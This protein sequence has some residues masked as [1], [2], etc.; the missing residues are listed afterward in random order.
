MPRQPG[1]LVCTSVWAWLQSLVPILIHHTRPQPSI[2]P[3]ILCKC[4]LCRGPYSLAGSNGSALTV[5][6]HL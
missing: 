5:G 4:V 3:A 1:S 6:L 2:G